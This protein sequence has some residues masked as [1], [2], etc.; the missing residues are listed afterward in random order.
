MGWIGL[1]LALTLRSECKNQQ[2]PINTHDSE[3]PDCFVL[4][5]C[6]ICVTYFFNQCS[7]FWFPTC[8]L[9]NFCNKYE[10]N[11]WEWHFME[12][13]ASV[14]KQLAASLGFQILLTNQWQN[15]GNCTEWWSP[16]DK[17]E[18]AT[19]HYFLFLWHH[20]QETDTITDYKPLSYHH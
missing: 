10:H 16:E 9:K 20:Q 17:K 12:L 19:T 1:R 8:R 13:T 15:R 3:L 2:P 7:V 6:D 11:F 5:C 18:S 4:L 14:I